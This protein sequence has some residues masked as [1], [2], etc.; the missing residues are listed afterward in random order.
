MMKRTLSLALALLML[1]GMAALPAASAE[2]ETITILQRL[3]ASF[4]VEDNPVIKAWGDM[5]GVKIEIEAP[6]ISNYQ[7]RRN[8][9]LASGDLPDLIWVGDQG[10]LYTQWAR[11]GLF[12]DLSKYLNEKDMPNAYKVLKPE[13]LARV[14]VLLEDGTEGIFSLPRVQTKPLDGYMYRGDWLKKLNLEVPRTPAEFA[15]VMQAFAKQDPDGNG[16]DDTY[17]WS[18]NTVMGADYRTLIAAFGLRPSEVPNAEGKYEL[19]QAQPN[20]MAFMDWIRG[21]YEDGSMDPEFYLT[22]MYEDDDLFYAGKLGL[23]YNQKTMEHLNTMGTNDAFVGANPEGWLKPGAPLMAE[24]DTV[25]SIYYSAQIWGNWAISAESKHIDLIIKFLDAGYTDEVNELLAFGLKGVTYEEFDRERR[26]ATRTEEQ[27]ANAQK[28]TSTYATIN[29]QTADK[30]MLITR[31]KTEAD[32]NAFLEATEEVAKRSQRVTYLMGNGVPGYGDAMA[33]IT[34]SGVNDEWNE[35]R[36]KY[37]TGQVD[38]DTLQ[39]FINDKMVP[40][41][42]PLLDLYA[43]YDGG[44]GINK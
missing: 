10:A 6:P 25:A 5:F 40:A 21:M 12:V 28:F 43:G 16:K 29:F 26:F 27:N 44:K 34:E 31:G 23:A 2:G 13:E 15:K 14:K 19:M 8:V 11:D 4:V 9:I 1:L 38:K 35:L 33:A 22:K 32:A 37:I 18:Y 7:D 30:G 39:A 36:T 3:P 20:Y 41:Y 42:Q 24:D 17:G